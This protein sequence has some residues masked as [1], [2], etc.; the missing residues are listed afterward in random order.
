[1]VPLAGRVGLTLGRYGGD[2]TVGRYRLPAAGECCIVPFSRV[3]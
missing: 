1:M 3:L 2:V